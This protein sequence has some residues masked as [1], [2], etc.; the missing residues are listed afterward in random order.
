MFVKT[1][2]L[3]NLV[4][5]TTYENPKW[6]HYTIN[7][8][9]KDDHKRKLI[10]LFLK[11]ADLGIDDIKTDV[12]PVTKVNLPPDFPDE[13][14][15]YLIKSNA[16]TFDIKTIHL[17]KNDD[18]SVEKVYFDLEDD[19]S[20]GTIKMFELFGPFIDILINGYTLVMDE[21]DTRL[22]PLLT[23]FLV[24]LFQDPSINKSCAQ[25]IFTTHDTNLLNLKYFRRDQ[26]WFTE[27]NHE[28]GFT[29]LYSLHDINP[30]KDEN[31]EKGYLAGRYGAVPFLGTE[32]LFDLEGEIH[33]LVE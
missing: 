3:K 28:L 26:I 4:T 33:N 10:K 5:R 6:R 22:H 13:L 31:I 23:Q 1:K 21:L 29:D 17:A 20:Q 32:N 16:E 24:K 7:A 12:K 19:E 25:L 11:N 30:R 9:Q 14:K 15:N 8:L 27:K 2:H 18:G